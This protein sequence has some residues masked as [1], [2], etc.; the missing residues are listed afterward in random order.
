M[1]EMSFKWVNFGHLTSMTLKIWSRSNLTQFSNKAYTYYGRIFTY[2]FIKICTVNVLLWIFLKIDVDLLRFLVFFKY[3]NLWS[4]KMVLSTGKL[5]K[6]KNFCRLWIRT[7]LRIKKVGMIQVLK[8]HPKKCTVP[9][10][11]R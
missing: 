4:I 11:S 5:T 6:F 2:V 9:C 3:T 10:T 8:H 1:G 7:K